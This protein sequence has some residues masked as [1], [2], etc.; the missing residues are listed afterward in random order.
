MPEHHNRPSETSIFV[1]VVIPLYNEEGNVEHLM[2]RIDAV[3]NRL[4][5]YYE[6][7]LVDDGST[8]TTWNDIQT[9]AQ[10]YTHIYGL[11]LSRN[12]GHQY[13]M[14]AGMTYAKGQAIIT[15]D[16][17]LQHPPE[18]IPDMLKAWESGYKIVNTRRIEAK[19]TSH[20][21]RLTSKYFYK[22]FSSLSEVSVSEGSSDF[23]LIDR[24]VWHQLRQF[25]DSNIFLRGAVQWVGFPTTCIAFE[26]RE[27]FANKSKFNFSR[28]LLFASGAIV[29]FSTKPLR[30]GIWL[31]LL[32]SLL[33][34]MEIIY[35]VIQKIRGST[36]P[37][38]ASTVGILSL[39][40]G[41]LFIILGI[42]GVY[43]ARIHKTLQERP[44][45]I[46]TE[47]IGYNLDEQAKHLSENPLAEFM[48]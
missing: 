23:R 26:V 27:R 40:F 21:K 47:N 14:L 15:M 48:E 42:I 7:I 45:F 9:G 18:L 34:F 25:R 41:I 2:S 20:F 1:S 44:R 16:G 10:K 39:L 33:A 38:W 43:L 32:T 17:D 12:F 24:Q 30:L 11:R 3:L 5:T 4:G 8:D 46:V 22:I 36:V 19:N 31:G 28:M 29:S 35:I 6:V 13:A 37:G